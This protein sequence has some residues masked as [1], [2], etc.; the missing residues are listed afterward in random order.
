M[1]DD[2]KVL[3]DYTPARVALGRAGNGLPTKR[4]LEFQLAHARARDAVHAPF[5]AAAVAEALAPRPTM[6]LTTQAADRAAYLA[7]PDLGRRLSPESAERLAP[8]RYDAVLVIADG[9]SATAIGAHG[10][11]LAAAILAQTGELAWA[12]VAIVSQG[13]VAVGDAIAEALGAIFA[14][15]MI[16]ERPGLSAADSV[17]LY[18]TLHPRAG[19]SSDAER[20]CISNVRPGGLGY[21]EAAHRLAWLIGAA[22]RLG[23][24]GVALKEDAPESLPAPQA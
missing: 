18:L 10:A 23:V 3:A 17:G 12:P 21:D 11:A 9:L 14:V 20:N 5:D 7:N 13:R 8:G 24:T 15:V 22:Q 19:A 2:W 1:S 4:V 16:G 6:L